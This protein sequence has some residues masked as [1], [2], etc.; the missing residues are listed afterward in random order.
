MQVNKSNGSIQT[1][2]KE[3]SDSDSSEDEKPPVKVCVGYYIINFVDSLH[4]EFMMRTC[5]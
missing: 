2:K 4:L 1:K 5:Y 3:S